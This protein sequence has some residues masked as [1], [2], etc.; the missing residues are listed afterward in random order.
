[1]HQVAVLCKNLQAL[2]C[3]I[4]AT[5]NHESF[6]E[7]VIDKNGVK[8]PLIDPNIYLSRFL[9]RIAKLSS[10]RISFSCPHNF[11][12]IR[13]YLLLVCPKV[14]YLIF[15][16]GISL[17]DGRKYIKSPNHTFSSLLSPTAISRV[18]EVF[19]GHPR[20]V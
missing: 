6:N 17:F 3:D 4:V 15:L 2:I 16:N 11:S 8:F 5:L 9:R 18:T 10:C 12:G 13:K 20:L 19:R 7:G 1:M 14:N